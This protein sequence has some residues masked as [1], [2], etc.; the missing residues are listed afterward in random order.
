M[1]AQLEKRY[2]KMTELEKVEKLREKANVSFAEAKE[3]L[4]KSG[5]DILDALIYLENQGKVTV[6]AGGGFFSGA[7]LPA[8]QERTSSGNSEK[9]NH[10]GGSGEEFADLMKRFGKFCLKMFN[11][12]LNNYLEASKGDQHLFS[13][14]ILIVILLAMFFFWVTIPLFVISLFCGFR[15]RF[16]G[17][18]L[19]RDSVNNM[20][21][22]ASDIVDDVK[23]SFTESANKSEDGDK[24]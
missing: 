4:D 16:T 7:D 5:G 2:K 1:T 10:H 17:A 9:S 18:D 6:P 24:E 11:K 8:Q 20:M 3:A 15:Y 21:D 14:P 12:G 13:C 22:S 23:R 19:G